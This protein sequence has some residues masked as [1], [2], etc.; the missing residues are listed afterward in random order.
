[1]NDLIK[2]RVEMY[3]TLVSLD[4]T[5][6]TIAHL[7]TAQIPWLLY[8]EYNKQRILNGQRLHNLTVA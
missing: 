7:Y 4:T 3:Q 6:V 5:I 2:I 8:A 1:M